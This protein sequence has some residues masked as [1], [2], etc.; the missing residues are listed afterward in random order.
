MTLLF[1]CTPLATTTD[2]NIVAGEAN[3]AW[4]WVSGP[5]ASSSVL[6]YDALTNTGTPAIA[7]WN[8]NI[9]S[10]TAPFSFMPQRLVGAHFSTGLT[11]DVT[12]NATQ[13]LNLCYL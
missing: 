13:V 12:L 7:E 3:L 9:S 10:T 1:N 4:Y 8:I 5:G 6:F 2:S 11:V